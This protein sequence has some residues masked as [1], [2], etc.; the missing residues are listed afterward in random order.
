MLNV[1][2][3]KLKKTYDQFFYLVF[4]FNCLIICKQDSFEEDYRFLYF[5]SEST[6]RKLVSFFLS[7]V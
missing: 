3:N 2:Q 5:R 6:G 7:Q 1:T 4:C